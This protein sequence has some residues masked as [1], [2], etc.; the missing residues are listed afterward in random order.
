[1]VG[2]STKMLEVREVVSEYF[3]GKNLDFSSNPDTAIS[4]G[5]AIQGALISG[6]LS[7]CFND[8]VPVAIGIRAYGNTM[9]TVINRNAQVPAKATKICKTNKDN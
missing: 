2:G 7:G 3:D 1:M 5:A 4:V 8:I 9:H 6:E